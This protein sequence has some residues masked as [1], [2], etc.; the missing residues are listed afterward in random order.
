[1]R[2]PGLQRPGPRRPLRPG[3][4]GARL[5]AHRRLAG[6]PRAAGQALLRL[7]PGRAAWRQRSAPPAAAGRSSSRSAAPRPGRRPPGRGRRTCPAGRPPPPPAGP[8]GSAAPPFRSP[9][10]ARLVTSVA[11]RGLAGS[12]GRTC[13]ASAASSSTTS[14]LRPTSALRYAAT[15]PSSSPGS[16]PWSAR[17]RRGSAGAPPAGPAAAVRPPARPGRLGSARRR[18]FQRGVPGERAA[19]LASRGNPAAHETARKPA[20]G[21]PLSFC[22][23]PGQPL[24]R[25]SSRADGEA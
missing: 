14:T 1:M 21:L 5:P 9:R 7:L 25:R 3:A 4:L 11:E 24:A 13:A 6:R 22:R 19:A 10:A 15:A 20:S 23:R 18:R 16:R 8:P 12:S 2:R 17:A